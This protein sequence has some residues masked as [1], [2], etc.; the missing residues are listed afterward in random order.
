MFENT[1]IYLIGYPGAGKL[2]IAR[3]LQKLFPSILVDNHYVNNVVF[4]LIDTDG[5]TPLPN[6]VWDYTKEIRRLVLDVIRELAKPKRNFI[7]TNALAAGDEVDEQLF[8]EIVQLALDRGANLLPVRVLV[9][10][11]ELCR[12]VA[13]PERKCLLK[14]IDPEGACA[15]MDDYSILAPVNSFDLE[16]SE[17]SPAEASSVIVKELKRRFDT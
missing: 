4:N 6:R 8:Q 7:F 15:A 9:S 14:S 16:T 17:L 2:T 1:F 11:E 12:R 5:I 10:R 3:E 13:S